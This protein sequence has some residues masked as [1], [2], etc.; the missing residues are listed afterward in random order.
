MKTMFKIVAF[1][2]LTMLGA[3][4]CKMLSVSFNFDYVQQNYMIGSLIG[5]VMVLFVNEIS[6]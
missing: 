5:A 6:K 3:V 1:L 4:I 2:G